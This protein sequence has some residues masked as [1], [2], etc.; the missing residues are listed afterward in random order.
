M[1]NKSILAVRI[2]LGTL[3]IVFGLNGFF[4]FIQLPLPTPEAGAFLGALAK[5]G[6]IFPIVKSI[7]IL[8]GMSLILNRYVPL[9]LIVITPILVVITLHHLILD[10]SGIGLTVLLVLLH[11][12]LVFKYNTF[13]KQLFSVKTEV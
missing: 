1:R 2:L 3:F 13:Y 12:F 4:H 8:F 10:I 5:T 7:E 9:A 6:F 11:G